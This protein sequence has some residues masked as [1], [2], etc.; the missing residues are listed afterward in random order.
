MLPLSFIAIYI[1]ALAHFCPCFVLGSP[2]ENTAV[3]ESHTERDSTNQHPLA[4]LEIPPSTHEAGNESAIALERDAFYIFN[5]V[6]HLLR[7]WGNTYMPNG[8]S[9]TKGWIPVGTNLYHARLVSS[10]P[11]KSSAVGCHPQVCASCPTNPRTIWSLLLLNGW[12]LTPKCVCP[13]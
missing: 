11:P 2:G 8:F 7:Q 6:H 13:D 12:H 5:S 4:Y 9:F 1:L 10:N 3:S